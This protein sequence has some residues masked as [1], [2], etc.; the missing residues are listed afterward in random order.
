VLNGALSKWL[1]EYPPPSG[2]QTRFKIKYAV[3]V[4]A[5]PVKFV[6][7][8]SRPGAVSKAYRAYL[9]NKIRKDLGYPHIPVE[10]EIRPS[11]RERE[12]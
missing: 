3:Q 7:F 9:G 12:S 6:F 4:S 10:V 1:E 5:N 8:A 11:R 2:P